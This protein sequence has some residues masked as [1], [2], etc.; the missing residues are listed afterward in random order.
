MKKKRSD[1]SVYL[2]VVLIALSLYTLFLAATAVWALYTSFK[3]NIAYL[4]DP[5]GLPKTWQCKNIRTALDY[6]M[7]SVN[8][9]GDIVDIY[10]ERMFLYSALYS[11]GSAFV[12]AF[13]A[14]VT[15]Y[16]TAKFDFRFNKVIYAIVIVTMTLPIVGSQYPSA[17]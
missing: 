5:L 15:A 12:S 2:I 17:A 10:I 7:V 14:C 8:M 4:A 3:G 1:S 16:V 6:Y 9:S 13:V 11:L